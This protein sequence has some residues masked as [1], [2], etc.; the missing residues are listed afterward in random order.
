MNYKKELLDNIDK[1]HTTEL[2]I[3]RIKKNL[4]LE[5]N[6]VVEICIELIKDEKSIVTKKGKNYYISINNKEL[7]VNSSS[8]TI[9]TAHLKK[10]KLEVFS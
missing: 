1:I 2:G 8:F 6:D 5:T 9:I 10:N 3:E 7:T 4:N